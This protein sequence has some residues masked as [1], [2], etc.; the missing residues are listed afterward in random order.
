MPTLSLYDE[1]FR[2]QFTSVW[3][4]GAHLS[5]MLQVEAALARA[6]AAEGVIPIE[7]AQSIEACCNLDILNLSELRIGAANAGN[8]AIPLVHQL[9]AA[10]RRRNADAAGFVHWGA[11]SQDII[12]TATVLQFRAHMDILRQLMED[13][14]RSLASL[15]D[16]HRRSVMPGRTWLQHAVPITFGL[17]AA[18]WL[19]AI[20]RKSVG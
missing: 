5:A 7:A 4:D 18:G 19:D 20:D 10:V 16:V 1:L 17:K 14:C 3:D 9:T 2:S 15:V 8:L 12:D 6:E 13:V 11:T